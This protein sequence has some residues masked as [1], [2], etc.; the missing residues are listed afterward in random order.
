M[1]TFAGKAKRWNPR[2]DIERNLA[3]KINS[4]EVDECWSVLSNEWSA[5][6][7]SSIPFE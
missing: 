2:E 6:N 3:G 1:E 4:V 7:C 5:L